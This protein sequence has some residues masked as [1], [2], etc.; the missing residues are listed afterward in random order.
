MIGFVIVVIPLMI[1]IISSS[2]SGHRMC[3]SPNL[4][5]MIGI[6]DC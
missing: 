3:S 4:G 2:F 5:F 6:S 1:T